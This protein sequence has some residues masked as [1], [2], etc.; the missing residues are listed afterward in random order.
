MG[1]DPATLALVATT[2]LAAGSTAYQAAN[3]PK[4]P[5]A[6]KPPAEAAP[7]PLPAAANN[8]RRRRGAASTVLTGPMGLT[9]EPVA[10]AKTLLGE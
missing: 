7:P 10:K 4:A 9:G 1:A 6:P 3:K 5:K 8:G 2:V